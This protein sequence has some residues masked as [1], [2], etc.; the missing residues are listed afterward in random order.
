MKIQLLA[1][2]L[3]LATAPLA[4]AGSGHDHGHTHGGSTHSHSEAAAKL[5]EEGAISVAT[6]ALAAIIENKQP[7]EGTPLDAAWG[8][9]A[10]ADKKISKKG[11]G[12]YIVSFDIKGA[13]RTL[14]VLLS[15]TGEIFDANYS[16]KFKDLKD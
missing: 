13:G 2:T 12:Y 3:M 7:V 5:D 16:G 11:N 10:I 6:K 14:Y 1:A 15:D 8:N 9:T 4:Y